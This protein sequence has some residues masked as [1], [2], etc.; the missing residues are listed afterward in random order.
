MRDVTGVAVL[1]PVAAGVFGLV[2]GLLATARLQGR[3]L[4]SA[5]RVRL[6]R[7]RDLAVPVLSAV[8]C[9]AFA[10]RFGPTPVLP[11]Y[12]YLALVAMPLGAID[13]E[14]HRLP[15]RLTLPSYPIA[16]GLLGVAA[17]FVASGG[18]HFLGALIGLAVLGV[19]YLVMFF[20][21]PN[22]FGLG[23]VKLAGVL[24]AYLGW[25]GVDAWLVGTFLGI[26][27]GGVTALGL[28]ALRKATR[29]SMIAF[30]PY[31][32]AG[33]LVAVLLSEYRLLL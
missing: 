32:L 30:G 24:G 15:D 11:A 18:R 9:A 17:P 20:L 10:V 2:V 33:A 7:P 16:L 8:A 25:L 31:M 26:V 4:L 5:W 23:D 6:D 14:E 22:G 21:N 13:V 29:K 1:L 19:L 27:F 12:L 3:S 28:L